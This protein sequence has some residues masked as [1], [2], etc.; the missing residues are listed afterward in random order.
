MI[1]DLIRLCPNPVS[2]NTVRQISEESDVYT[3]QV[4]TGN[5]A[6]AL[7]CAPVKTLRLGNRKSKLGRNSFVLP[8]APLRIRDYPQ[9]HVPTFMIVLFR[10]LGS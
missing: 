2:I 10:N 8:S 7:E 5:V 9:R 4:D 3:I 6:A 1:S